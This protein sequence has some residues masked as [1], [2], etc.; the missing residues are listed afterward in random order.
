MIGTQGRRS[1]RFAA[2][3]AATFVAASY[4]LV[5]VA[6]AQAPAENAVRSPMALAPSVS[7]MA[8]PSFA[9][10][11]SAASIAAGD[12]TGSGRADVIAS[13]T[14]SGDVVVY[15]SD[16]H[17]A[18]SA[19]VR[20]PA[21]SHPGAVLVADVDG[22]GKPDAIIA[23]ATSGT[24]TILPGLG[25]GSF[26]APRTS[27]VG[28]NPGFL[29]I[30]DFT[31]SGHSDL[32]V[33]GLTT[34]ALAVLP[35]DGK[36]NFGKPVTYPTNGIPA[37]LAAADFDRDRHTDLAVAQSDGTVAIFFGEG[38]S[39]FRAA[40]PVAVSTGALTSVAAADF[41]RD[42]NL[43]L[44]VTVGNSHAA[45]VLLG[46]GDGT[47]ASPVSYDVG[48]LPVRLTVADLDAD[49]IP[50]LLVTNRG[51][52]TFS[53]LKGQGDGTFAPASNFVAGNKPQDAVA[54][55]FYGSGRPDLAVV[56]ADSQTMTV[57][58]GNGDSSFHAARS[59]VVGAQPVALASA[60]LNGDGRPD[61]VVANYCG[62]DPSCSGGNAV[63][64]LAE[65]NGTYQTGSSY[66]LG[67]GP[68]SVMLRDVN[69]DQI[70]DLVA[71]NR[72]DRTLTVRLGQGDGT[73]GQ[74]A[75][76]S[77]AG[78]P[79]ALAS[80]D[81]NRLGKTDLAVVEDCGAATCSQPGAVE[82]L[83]GERD[84]TFASQGTYP[85]G[86]APVSLAVGSL[87][88]TA[89]PGIVVVNRCGSVADCSA[90][91]TATVLLGDGAGHFRAGADI[92]L[93]AHPASIA[94][95]DLSGSGKLDAVISRASDNAVV[96]YRGNGDGAFQGGV[97]YPVGHA[98]GHLVIADFTGDGKPDVAVISAA[99]S[100]VNLLAGNGDGTLQPRRSL[101]V[102]TGP[103]ALAVV[104]GAPGTHPG[105]ATVNGDPASANSG[106][107]MTV[108]PSLLPPAPLPPASVT[109]TV[110]PT[111]NSNVND[112]VTLSV[113]VTSKPG[114]S[115]VGA[116][117]GIITFNY[118]DLA[119]DPGASRPV[120]IPDCEDPTTK[121]PETYPI[122]L[123]ANGNASCLTHVLP[124]SGSST[125]E[126][127]GD[128]SGN[129]ANPNN[130]AATN[131]NAVEQTV[132][133][134]AATLT[135]AVTPGSKEPIGTTVTFTPQLQA[136]SLN[137]NPTGLVTW[138]I[139]GGTS[140]DCPP[141]PY[142]AGGC[143]TASL[144]APSDQIQAT[145]GSD[146]S[147]TV[148]NP[149][150]VDETITKATPTVTI[151]SPTNPS[152][153][154]QQIT[155]K[156]QVAAP[157][158]SSPAVFP[159][160][161]VSF[162]PTAGASCSSLVGLSGNPGTASCNYTFTSASSGINLTVTYGGDQ[163]FFAGSPAS[164]SQVVNAAS[165][166]IQLNPSTTS[167]AVN[168]GMT[169][170]AVVVPQFTGAAVPQGSVTI[171]DTTTATTIC[172]EKLTSGV[173]ASCPFTFSASGLHVVS[174]SF[175]TS[176]GN[177]NSTTQSA[178]ANINVG[179]GSTSVSLTSNLNPSLV[180]Q[181]VKFT[182]AISTGGSARNLNGTIAYNDT[183]TGATLCSGNVTS[184]AVPTCTI[185]FSTATTH[186]VVAAFTS[187]NTNQF[188]SASS[189]PLNQIVNPASTTTTVV[190]ASPAPSEVSQSVTYTVSVATSPSTPATPTGTVT[191]N[192][193][194]GSQTTAEC[195]VTL[196]ATSCSAPLA[197]A[198]TYTITATYSGDTNFLTSTSAGVTHKVG[199]Q[200][201]AIA[202][203]GPYA[204]MPGSSGCTAPAAITPAVNQMV[205][206][207]ATLTPNIAG[208]T[209]PTGSVVFGDNVNTTQL[210][211]PAPLKAATVSSVNVSTAVCAITFLSSAANNSNLLTVNY[212]GDNNFP[213]GSQTAALT[214]QKASTNLSLKSLTAVSVATT[215]VKFTAT[216][217][218][219]FAGATLA[220][221][222]GTIAFTSSDGTVTAACPAIPLSETAGSTVAT[223]TCSVI[224]PHVS[225]TPPGQISV[226]A[227]YAG[228]ANFTGS[229]G[230]T[231]QTVED[232]NAAFAVTPTAASSD[233]SSSTGLFLGQGFAN[234]ASTGQIADPINGATVALNISSVSNF[235]DPLTVTCSVVATSVPTPT[236][237]APTVPPTCSLMGTTGSVTLNPPYTPALDVQ[238]IAPA[239][240]T[241]GLYSLNLSAVDNTNGAAI[242]VPISL[243]VSIVPLSGTMDLVAGASGSIQVVFNTASAPSGDTLASFS[244][245]DVVTSTGGTA[246]ISPTCTGASTPVTGVATSVPIK[247]S[248]GT[249]TTAQAHPFAGTWAFA[250]AAPF[251]ALMGWFGTRKSARRNFFRFLGMILVIAAVATLNGCGGSFSGPNITVNK[252]VK[253]GAYYIEVVAKDNA[254]TPNSYY[255][256]I[257]VVITAE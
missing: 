87:V 111:P 255:T 9:L 217:T 41:N 213:A 156:G 49:G 124:G 33:A 7:L 5:P 30:G 130:Y 20:Y 123:D 94:L 27:T 102:G 118:D 1:S 232:F 79:V 209:V 251:M 211:S 12:L 37:G 141:T 47:F 243:P 96:V 112:G 86:F 184:G 173:A 182:A 191:V 176:D 233:L 240:A 222:T 65:A 189:S 152:V 149:V 25:N 78:S 256:I 216:L 167:P 28:F 117:T 26:G 32:A 134:I 253:P 70:L 84:G 31:G 242:N 136:T 82:I 58:A 158:G 55:G 171:T 40:T 53:V 228:D 17:G 166:T 162:T 67:A 175:T 161:N 113:S 131:S 246:G 59:Y 247:V 200:G 60:D 195:T 254:S 10:G 204:C 214:V 196:P 101:T 237:S 224:F 219:Q 229:V 23:N 249:T 21:G 107:E 245:F 205:W 2:L 15:L 238:I 151:S 194:L 75:T 164:V 121:Q 61:L 174:A 126:L 133:A 186:A 145:Y 69:G 44:A 98:P 129:T 116:A 105:L 154:N 51:S 50:D 73:F 104:G 138:L 220:F 234:V 163:N 199:T 76:I 207:S 148:Q 252:T 6:L 57:A 71:A 89:K 206:F 63:V 147:Y 119:T 45:M 153:V 38:N 208:T 39:R 90:G 132:K 108:L 48:N 227:T 139:N 202:I 80:G 198:G 16:G 236:T 142:G 74:P 241:V 24:I 223:A 68:V 42:G 239:T 188:P 109:L 257:P 157:S 225:T 66:T 250:F 54:A 64:L 210:C 103:T 95:A 135:L 106:R 244:C 230:S 179:A 81:F 172:T 192:A 181:Q 85:A 146:L 203:G 14:A 114:G 97:A 143:T 62:A 169:F 110:S 144:V 56:N 231:T 177:F 165:T 29:A 187:S 120:P 18:F 125:D 137:T 91:G 77:L 92:G 122:V 178:T 180:N 52:N 160:G 43:D 3:A 35:N 168:V 100:S 13:D 212:A 115:N 99:D 36:G 72:L 4:C 128:Y 150:T 34:R 193:T 185:A 201:E 183:T 218:L 140:S 88:G 235:A 127:T 46:K 159:T 248:F 93:G 190:S 215:S 19:G 11:Y 197:A 8:A 83:F 155:V 226:S 221:P 170:Q 22:D